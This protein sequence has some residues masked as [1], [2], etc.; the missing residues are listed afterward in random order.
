MHW[1]THGQHIHK[2]HF[3]RISEYLTGANIFERIKRELKKLHHT[4]KIYSIYRYIYIRHKNFH[5]CIENFNCGNGPFESSSLTTAHNHSNKMSCSFIIVFNGTVSHLEP[6]ANREYL[7]MGFATDLERSRYSDLHPNCK[8]M[9]S[10]PIKK[11]FFRLLCFWLLTSSLQYRYVI[12]V[13]LAAFVL[14]SFAWSIAGSALE[15]W[16]MICCTSR[17]VKFLLNTKAWLG[18]NANSF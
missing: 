10:S 9:C 17:H 15:L 7:E 12:P 1:P 14:Q 6:K 3:P 4:H 2:L 13:M 18:K 16:M 8:T 11:K 5:P